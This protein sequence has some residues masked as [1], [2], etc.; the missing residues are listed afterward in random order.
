MLS[1]EEQT[2]ILEK[3]GGEKV[4]RI[5]KIVINDL[6]SFNILYFKDSK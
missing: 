1:R 5:L 2:E 3:Y 6:K 4:L